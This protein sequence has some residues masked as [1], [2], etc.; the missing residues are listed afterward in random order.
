MQANFLLCAGNFVC[1]TMTKEC[2]NPFNYF[3]FFWE[4][5][6]VFFSS[7][8]WIKIQ[9]WQKSELVSHFFLQPNVFLKLTLYM[10]TIAISLRQNH[11]NMITTQCYIITLFHMSRHVDNS[12]LKNAALLSLPL[13]LKTSKWC[14]LF[15]SA[16]F[17]AFKVI[18][19]FML[20]LFP[21][22]KGMNVI[23]FFTLFHMSRHVDNSM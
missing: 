6:C 11:D 21:E 5:E 7:R 2:P 17:Y 1:S 4:W 19:T 22:R 14:C 12:M 3:F 9:L 20:W 16:S 10:C 23:R 8:I 15:W 18:C 13:N